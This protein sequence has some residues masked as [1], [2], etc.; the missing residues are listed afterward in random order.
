LGIGRLDAEWRNDARVGDRTGIRSEFYQPLDA[1]LRYFVAPSLTFVREDSP[2][3]V[4]GST[5]ALLRVT[6]WGGQVDIG[7]NL[8]SWGQF[9]VGF[10]RAVGDPE[11]AIGS[12]VTGLESSHIARWIASLRYD[13]LDSPT[14]PT[15][16]GL[17]DVAWTKNVASLGGDTRGQDLEAVLNWTASIGRTRFVPGMELGLDLG[18]SDPGDVAFNLGGLFRLSGYGPLELIGAESALGRLVAYQ[19]LNK[20]TLLVPAGW[21]AGLSLESGNVFQ[22]DESID[23]S[24]FLFG[25]AAFIG[26]DTPLGPLIFGYGYTEP[27]RSRFYLTFGRSFF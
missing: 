8:G 21:Y 9:R 1:R 17:G 25:A 5:V 27:D 3:F 11:I 7:R 18:E 15:K 23:V 4:D 10:L 26:L 14:W 13:T 19:Q 2:V 20:K 24:E 12:P 16:G 22:G 6:V